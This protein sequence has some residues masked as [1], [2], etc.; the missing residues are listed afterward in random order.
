MSVVCMHVLCTMFVSGT[1]GDQKRMSDQW[2]LELWM[3]VGA[4]N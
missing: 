1:L 3:L 4:G 2:K